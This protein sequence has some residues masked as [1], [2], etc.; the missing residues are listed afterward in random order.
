MNLKPVM[1]SFR[2]VAA[3]CLIFITGGIWGCNESSSGSGA[4]A[5]TGEVVIG[6]TD[7]PGDF[8]S[9]TVDVI[10]VS[11]TRTNGDTVETLPLATMV[12]FAQ[13]TDLTEFL[14]AATVPSGV[15]REVAM[16]LDYSG[17]EIYVEDESG[18]PV[19]VETILDAEGNPI[20]EPLELTLTFDETG[21]LKIAPG[22]PAHMTLDFDLAASN[23]V[24]FDETGAPQ[25]TVSPTLAAAIEPEA[26]KPHRLRGPMKSVSPGEHA[27]TVIIRPF[28]H[29]MDRGQGKGQ[30]KEEFGKLKVRVNAETVY[31]ID[32]VAYAGDAGLDALATLP[33]YT[34]VVVLGDLTFNPRRFDAREVRAGTSIPG[35]AMDVV[36][37]NVT[38]RTDETLT[39]RGASVI[40]SGNAAV[41]N[42]EVTVTIGPETDVRRQLSTDPLTAADIPVGQRLMV[43][44]SFNAAESGGE[45]DATEPLVLDATDGYVMMELSRVRGTVVEADPLSAD[46]TPL[47]INLQSVDC[48]GPAAHDFAGAGIDPAGF[49]VAT[50][51]L[52][53]SGLTYGD[54]VTILGFFAADPSNGA[55]LT[56]QTLIAVADRQAFLK[57]H[58][59]PAS[60]TAFSEISAARLVLDLSGAGLFHH[61]T[62]GRTVT[63]L[64]DGDTGPVIEPRDAGKGLFEIV[65]GGSVYTYSV[66]GDFAAALEARIDA[67]TAVW[68]C[69]AEGKFDDSRW[70]MEA[71]YVRV[72]LK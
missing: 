57:V 65:Y 62:R 71:G 64:A 52:D 29:A 60:A 12:D 7:A 56:A 32:G 25:I 68:Q 59:R 23:K 67:G 13:Y 42:D 14:T 48:Y 28:F 9:Y 36:I 41:F 38:D 21:R 69:D 2:L 50:G 1:R 27:F 34:G 37:G 44:G 33:Q 40:R 30:W 61:V 17:A 70:A 49:E 46:E 11:L 24:V 35:G 47:V 15:Y 5:D 3:I 53:L 55:D 51:S 19:R 54:P 66:F 58:W 45:G 10:S 20:T 26:S 43:F 72:H 16:T 18:E 4:S 63:D 8:L 6:L 39:V 22:F 31:D